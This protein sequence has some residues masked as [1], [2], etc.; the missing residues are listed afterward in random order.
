MLISPV[1]IDIGNI[2]YS[3]KSN[4]L[5]LRVFKLI[6]LFLILGIKIVEELTQDYH[7]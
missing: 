5:S 4:L 6:V 7:R 1:N 2:E 3:G